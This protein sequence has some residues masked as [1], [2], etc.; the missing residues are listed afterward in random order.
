M[1]DVSDL[2]TVA[3]E[4]TVQLMNRLD[5]SLGSSDSIVVLVLN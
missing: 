1:V 3:V 5:V 2:N 4:F